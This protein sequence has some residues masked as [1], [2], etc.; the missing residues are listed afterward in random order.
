MPNL[1]LK[2]VPLTVTDFLLPVILM[3][4]TR[5]PQRPYPSRLVTW[6]RLA[7]PTPNALPSRDAEIVLLH[8]WFLIR[9]SYGSFWAIW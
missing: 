1:P 2:V 5:P 8:D 3:V 9:P 7:V 6:T 4:V